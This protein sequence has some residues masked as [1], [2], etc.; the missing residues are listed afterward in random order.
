MGLSNKIDQL[1]FNE[2]SGSSSSI[3]KN[4]QNIISTSTLDLLISEPVSFIKMD[5]EGWEMKAIEGCINHIINDTPKLAIT[6]YHNASDFIE[7]PK[8]ILS[9]NNNY[10]IYLRHYTS[11]WSETVMYF[12]PKAI[13]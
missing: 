9:F 4:G 12:V 5:I 8:Y 7:I 10:N 2:N 13:Q 1:N 3:I 6:V 11:G